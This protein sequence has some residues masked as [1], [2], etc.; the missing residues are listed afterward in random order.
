MRLN[1]G[2]G[3]CSLRFTALNILQLLNTPLSMGRTHN[4]E[5]AAPHDIK[6]RCDRS[7]LRNSAQSAPSVASRPVRLDKIVYSRIRK[8]INLCDW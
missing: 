5:N 4:E 8:A 1:A 3:R 2:L 6:S 7:F